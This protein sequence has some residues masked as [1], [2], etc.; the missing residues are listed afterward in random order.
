MKRADGRIWPYRTVQEG[1]RAK[2]RELIEAERGRAQAHIAWVRRSEPSASNDRVAQIIARRW[3]A[4]SGVEG[5]LTGSAGFVGVPL[6]L[7]LFSYSQIA[8]IVSIAECYGIALEASAGED[9]VLEVL[10]KAHGVEDVLRASP[11]VLGAIART[12]A[13]R[14]GMKNLG[15]L[16]PIISAPISAHLN[17]RDME[18]LADHAFRRFGRII[19][20]E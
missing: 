2:L 3:I 13:L 9:A 10:G 18:R 17:E 16:V 14:Y 19:S 8:L 7:L 6:N 1:A 15:R 4:I 5:G 11:R 12:L 20:I